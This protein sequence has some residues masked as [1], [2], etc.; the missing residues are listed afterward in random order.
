MYNLPYSNYYSYRLLSYCTAGNSVANYTSTQSIFETYLP[1][2]KC[3]NFSFPS[4]D[5]IELATNQVKQPPL[6]QKFIS[7]IEEH[8]GII[9]KVCHMYCSRNEDREDLFQDIVLQLWRSFP[10]FSGGSKVSTWMYRVALNVAITRLRKES[11]KEQ[12]RELNEEAL[13]IPEEP[14][15]GEKDKIMQQAIQILTDVEK[16]IVML[17]MDN[18]SYREI[19]ELVGISESNVGYKLNQIKHKL[20]SQVK[21][22]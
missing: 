10:S 13:N 16:A 4:K 15:D 17:Y 8:K 7:V 2:T 9:S 14:F 20:K 3:L 21:T 1:A 11:K 12:P 22:S 6:K 5:Y 19:G 18:Y